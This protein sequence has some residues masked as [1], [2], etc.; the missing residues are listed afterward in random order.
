MQVCPGL[1]HFVS[2]RNLLP[3]S[4]LVGA[5]DVDITGCTCRAQNVQRGDLFV[6][7]TGSRYDGH[8]FIAEAIDRGCGAVLT[9]R[10]LESLAS[11]HPSVPYCIVANARD[12][13][14]R[15]CH[16][17]A[18]NPSQKLKLIGVTGTNGKTTTSCLI[19]G[20]L[21]AA[22][23]QTGVLGTLGYLDG[24]KIENATHTTPPPERL[25]S[26][27]RR[28]VDNGCSHAVM[29]VSSHA[30]DQSRV[31]GACFD[32]ACVTNVTRDHLDYH[33][34]LHDYWLA[35]S[36]L[37]QHLTTEGFSVI[38]ADDPGSSAYLH[39]LNGPA[40]T[41]GIQTAA[42]VTAT[43]IETSLSEQTFLI[44]AGSDTAP[45]RTRMIGEHHIYNCLTATAVGLIYGIDLT[46]IVRGLESVDYV[47][48]RLERIECGQPFGVFVDYAHTPDALTHVLKSLRTVTSGRI[49]CV[50]G[51]GGER[52]VEKRPLMGRAVEQNADLAILTND[53]PRNEKP[54][55]I[56][57]EILSGFEEPSRA[58][59]LPDR[60]EAIAQ[61]LSM[62]RPGDCVLIAG[63]GH[64]TY[65][66][67]GDEKLP[68]DD[69]ET[70]RDWLYAHADSMDFETMDD[71]SSRN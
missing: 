19:A 71:F 15:I 70:A 63:K 17:L 29:E 55:V 11:Y 8:E 47:P 13:Y 37:F 25:A 6:A 32:A 9:D 64:E 36:K 41:V 33:A 67:V 24:K 40:L 30:L 5:E 60:G 14:G 34:S 44:H 39:Q 12:A 21:T 3:N 22:G 27:L 18:G 2:L 56:L 48:G 53:N 31:A 20:I 7:L 58:L 69:R 46:T 62:A 59:V 42:E 16:A 66:V 28:M 45:V 51:A 57:G 49:L 54:R 38:N 43:P 26:L 35:K 68:F 50:F 23:Y 65:Q 4:Q 61:A 10:P 52:D 1:G